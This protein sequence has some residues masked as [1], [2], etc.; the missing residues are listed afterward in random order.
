[1]NPGAKNEDMGDEIGN[2]FETPDL[3]IP[4]ISDTQYTADNIIRLREIEL[5]HKKEKNRFIQWCVG[6]VV[7]GAVAFACQQYFIH[8]D[9]M[10]V[11]HKLPHLTDGLRPKS[12]Y[13][14]V[15]ERSDVRLPDFDL[16]A[17]VSKGIKTFVFV[18]CQDQ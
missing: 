1:M 12:I 13:F 18:Y 6:A 3:D 8:Q 11:G 15:S 14:G 4:E 17:S 5:E 2:P 7:G 10:H 9:K 16:D